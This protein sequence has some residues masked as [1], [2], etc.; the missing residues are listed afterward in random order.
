MRARL[1]LRRLWAPCAWTGLLLPPAAAH[2]GPPYPIL[3]DEVVAGWTISVWA[4][5]DV[6]TGTFYY[7]VAPPAGRGPLDV[8]IEAISVPAEPRSPAVAGTSEPARPR[9]PFQQIGTLEFGHRGRWPTRFVVHPSGSE[10]VLG[11]LTF[12]LDVTPPGLGPRDV[13]LYGFPFLLIGG[14]WL[15]VLLAQRAYERAHP[16]P[17]RARPPDHAS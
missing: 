8:R 2:D 13:L 15:R 3:V 1:P 4:D 9:E 17:P 14:L 5:P 12:D 11:E 7:Y 16:D 6:G 10:N